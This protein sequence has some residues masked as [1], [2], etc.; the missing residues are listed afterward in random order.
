[1]NCTL[2]SPWLTQICNI[3]NECGFSYIW[4]SHNFAL[5]D[6]KWLFHSIKDILFDQFKQKWTSEIENSSRGISYRLF[7]QEFGFESYL[8][9]LKGKD[10]NIMCRFRCSNHKLPIETG[11]WSNIARN[12]RYCNLCTSNTLGDEF[13]YILECPSLLNDRKLLL[14]NYYCTRVNVIKFRDLFTKNDISILRKL[15]K[16]IKI[17]NSK[18]CPP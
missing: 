4:L 2:N 9:R 8:D 17:I 12:E 5:F 10:R 15:C 18:V 11:R 14:G 3:L 1:M 7:K 16:F 6:K 13:H